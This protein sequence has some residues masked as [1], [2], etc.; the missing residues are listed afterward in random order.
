MPSITKICCLSGQEFI[1]TEAD[2][3]FYKK[4][5]VP[6][7]T[8]RPQERQRRRLSF[9]NER[10]LYHRKCDLTGRQIISNISVD[11]PYKVYEKDVWWSDQWDPLELG[12]PYDFSRSFFEQLQELRIAVPRIS[13]FSKGGENVDYTNHATYNKNCYLLFN[14]T[15]CENVH[16]S[17][18]YV[19]SCKD[20]GDCY[21]IDHCELLYN[22]FLCQQCYNSVDLVNCKNC[23]DSAFLYDCRG[24]KNCMMCWGLRNKEY[25][26]ENKQYT[27]EEYEK[28]M[29]SFD[30]G[31]FE[32]YK[33]LQQRFKDVVGQNAP[34]RF[35]IIDQSENCTGDYIIQSKNTQDSFYAVACRDSRFI[36]DGFGHSDSY[37]CYECAFET[38]RQYECYACNYTKFSYFSHVTHESNAMYY[39][40]YC[41][42]SHDCFGCVS[43][44]R[45]QYCILN[46]QYSKQ[47]Y[48]DLKAR[49]ITQMKETREWGE[50]LPSSYSTFAYNESVAQ[51]FLP[52]TKKE[53][54]SR[55]L[56]WKEPENQSSH[57]GEPYQIPDHIKEVEDHILTATLKCDVSGKYY[58]I[59]P[60][61]LAFYRQ[62]NVP[63]PRR[64]FDQRHQDRLYWRNPRSLYERHCT[65]C[66]REIQTTYPPDRPEKIYCQDCYEKAIY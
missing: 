41:F 65:S 62:L 6:L 50:F 60:Q 27:K 4:I 16:Y 17:T 29:K 34:H 66:A 47:E 52:M 59:I 37:D 53:I 8:L 43:L 1:V 61:E 49:I 24:C 5:G 46:R 22:S 31:S 2:Q 64:C 10:N 12:R 11:K 38:E 3:E 7:P 42:N 32:N 19:V 33:K 28:I 56:E 13:L 9:R 63:I 39:T 14:A 21:S 36:Y 26:I 25:C 23:T 58:K 54:L 45:K 20:C 18:N 57:Q 15:L 44:K 51:D 48:E 55:G 35:A 30:L 40:D